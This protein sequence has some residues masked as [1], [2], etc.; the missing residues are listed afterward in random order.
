[1]CHECVPISAASTS[2]SSLP[3]VSLRVIKSAQFATY[4]TTMYFVSFTLYLPDSIAL[5]IIRSGLND[6]KLLNPQ[7]WFNHDVF[8]ACA[9]GVQSRRAIPD[10][11]IHKRDL[12]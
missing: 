4:I 5:L 7:G 8:R 2:S 3:Y 12:G 11:T 1:M 9:V 10:V 6:S